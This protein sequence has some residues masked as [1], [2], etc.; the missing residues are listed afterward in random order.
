MIPTM[1][2]SSPGQPTASKFAGRLRRFW[3]KSAREKR[4]S[5]CWNLWK[6]LPNLPVP[7]RLPFGA[8]WLVRG[9]GLD[10]QLLSGGFEDAELRFVQRF[11]RPGMTVLDVGAHH[12]LYTL[13]ASK[14]VGR[15]GRV[16][17]FEPSPRERQ[18]LQQHVHLNRC[19]NVRIEPFALGNED[20]EDN[21]H[22]VEGGDSGCNSLRRPAVTSRT[23]EV[24]V[25][26]IRLDDWLAKQRIDG[27]DFIKMDVEG[28]ELA[29]LQGTGTLL[30]TPPRPVF[31][32]E[33]YDIRTEPWGY[34]AREIV[35]FLDRI[36]YR[37]F[38]LL[39]GGEIQSIPAD[40]Q[41]Y[42][43]NLVAIPEESVEHIAR[44]DAHRI[45]TD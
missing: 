27:V 21:L 35:R 6:V 24:R 10:G 22:V 9:S 13:L 19:S 39:E 44:L 4:A 28:G 43:A 1:M 3:A 11:L 30:Q 5:L 41:T 18:R 16:V 12:G 15:H 34:G 40:R 25:R 14:R 2:L 45:G 32:A 20:K 42:D 8:W 26:V 29:V 17:A 36:G 38:R 7:L 31:L 33:V 23:S 37:W